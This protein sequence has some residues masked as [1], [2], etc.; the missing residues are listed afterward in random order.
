MF[1]VIQGSKSRIAEVLFEE[2]VDTSVIFLWLT[3]ELKKHGRETCH[4][5][6][7]TSGLASELFTVLSC[8]SRQFLYLFQTC[9]VCV[10]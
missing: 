10:L 8:K 3:L 6:V 5:E 7:D 1:H 2:L 9:E 4:Q